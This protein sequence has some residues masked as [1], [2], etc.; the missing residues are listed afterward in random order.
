[1]LAKFKQAELAGKYTSIF[2]AS[3]NTH[4]H[5]LIP[6]QNSALHQRLVWSFFMKNSATNFSLTPTQVLTYL[7]PDSY[8]RQVEQSMPVLEV[9][10]FPN[11]HLLF[12]HSSFFLSLLPPLFVPVNFSSSVR[13][14]T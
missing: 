6:K 12:Y 13:K 4:Q 11:P 1:M 2:L 8:L 3:K 5:K 7:I 14:T 9:M 10:S